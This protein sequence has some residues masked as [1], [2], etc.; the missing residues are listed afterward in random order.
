MKII[1][2]SSQWSENRKTGLGYCASYHRDILKNLGHNVITI[3]PKKSKTNY[4]IEAVTRIDLIFG[5][6]KTNAYIK[7]ILKKENPEIVIIESLQNVLSEILINISSKMKIKN[8]LISHGISIAPYK[9][10]IKYIL[11]SIIWIPYLLILFFLLKKVDILLTLDSNPNSLRHLD[12]I[13]YKKF[14]NKKTLYEYN[15]FSRL[16]NNQFSAQKFK[17]KTKSILLIGYLDSIKNQIDF[18]KIANILNNKDL[19]FKII[20]SEYNKNYLKKIN[21]YIRKYDMKNIELIDS[22]KV[23][24]SDEINNCWLILNT[25]ITEVMPL[26]IFEA[27][28]SNKLYLSYDIGSIKKIS[29]VIINKNIEQ[30]IFN[31]NSLYNNDKLYNQLCSNLKHNY[32]QKYSIKKLTEKFERVIC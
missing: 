20:F 12:T 15:N 9:F 27:M 19:I 5:Y 31:I 24:I 26:T 22:N 21:A 32:Y 23:N 4:E 14:Y 8:I 17:K 1:L 10:K 13:F 30:M 29:E 16:E 11:R 25:S 28:S 18:L 3:G 7:N 2:V 6:I